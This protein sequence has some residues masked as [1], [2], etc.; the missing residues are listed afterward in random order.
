MASEQT[1][2]DVLDTREAIRCLDH[3]EL[4]E[5]AWLCA[6]TLNSA[7]DVMGVGGI[8]IPTPDDAP[9][10]VANAASLKVTERCREI[11]AA[12]LRSN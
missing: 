3:E 1:E 7:C 10:D 9:I 8:A 11:R 4:F 5:F 12:R 2:Q 6:V